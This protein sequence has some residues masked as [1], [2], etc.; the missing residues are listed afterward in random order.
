MN[1]AAGLDGPGSPRVSLTGH[2]MENSS[3][4]TAGGIQTTPAFWGGIDNAAQAAAVPQGGSIE[5]GSAG[6][7]V[8]GAVPQS[9]Q[10]QDIRAWELERAN[11][12]AGLAW[13]QVRLAGT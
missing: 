4:L 10:A 3:Q 8:A 12:R 7:G 1:D 2:H 11:K 13:L 5:G 6:V 9:G